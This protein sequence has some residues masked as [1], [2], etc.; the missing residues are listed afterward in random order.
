MNR[1]VYLIQTDEVDFVLI[2][3]KKYLLYEL[4]VSLRVCVDI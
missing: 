3:E 4:L 2:I 1:Y